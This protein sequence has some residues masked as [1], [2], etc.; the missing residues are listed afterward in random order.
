[1]AANVDSAGTLTLTTNEAMATKTVALTAKS[2]GVTLTLTP[3][4]AAFGVLPVNTVAP[5]LPLTLTNTGN[6]PATITFTQPADAQFSLEWL[7]GS[8]DGFMLAAGASVA[9]LQ[10]GFTPSKITPSI[11]AAQIAVTEAICGTSV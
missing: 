10:A 3:S 9:G 2:A 6:I 8:P 7:T 1:S 4:V 5:M 11:S